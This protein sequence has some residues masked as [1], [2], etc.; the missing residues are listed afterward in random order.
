MELRSLLPILRAHW[1]AI[2]AFIVLGGAVAFGWSL[3]QPRV[4]SADSSGY[5]SAG[6]NSDTGN[7]LVGDN[8]AQSKVKSYIDIGTS[9]AVAQA[10]IDDLGLS[11]V[12]PEGLVGRITVS[13]PADTVLLKVT[14]TGPTPT[15]AR[16]LAE[17]WLRGIAGQIQAIENPTGAATSDGS[18][19]VATSGL[20]LIATEFQICVN[21]L[22]SPAR[23]PCRSSSSEESCSRASS[24]APT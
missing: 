5:V 13:N 23:G 20:S 1:I 9:R 16:D 10:A 4:Y 6:S 12:T 2:V 18:A 17:A 21:S 14:A 15:Q 3:L 22:N 8:L 11:G 7:A 19:S 24:M